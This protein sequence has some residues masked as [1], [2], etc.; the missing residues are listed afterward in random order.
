VRITASNSW[1]ASNSLPE[2]K[3][4]MTSDVNDLWLGKM[5]QEIGVLTTNVMLLSLQRDALQSKTVADAQLIDALKSRCHAAECANEQ[6][7]AQLQPEV[8]IRKTAQSL[9]SRQAPLTH[10]HVPEH[11]YEH[12]QTQTHTSI[13]EQGDGQNQVQSA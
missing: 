12:T 13:A 10:E 6:L 5:Q 4:Q 8:K 11:K 1:T 3:K 7:K 9:K 2:R